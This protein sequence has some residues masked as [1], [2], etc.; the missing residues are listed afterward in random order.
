LKQNGIEINKKIIINKMIIVNNKM[1]MKTPHT[2][3]ASING[4]KGKMKRKRK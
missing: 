2:T 1:K 3:E 4:L